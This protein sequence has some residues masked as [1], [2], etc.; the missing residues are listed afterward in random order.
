MFELGLD[1][2]GFSSEVEP[3]APDGDVSAIQLNQNRYATYEN[4]RNLFLTH[5]VRPSDERG[6]KYDIFIYLIRHREN[7]FEDVEFVIFLGPYCEIK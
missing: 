2:A 7:G 1:H 4:N 5:L 6:Q 3:E